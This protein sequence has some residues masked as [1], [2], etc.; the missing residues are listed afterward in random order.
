M[1][2]TAGGVGHYFTELAAADGAELTVVTSTPE[3]AERL[4][5]LGARHSVQSLS[6]AIGPFDLVLESVD[7]TLI[8]FG[9]ASREPAEISFFRLWNGPVSGSIRH[10]DY[11]DTDI[12][13]TADLA[14]LLQMVE[15]GRLH[16]ELGL[17]AD[18]SST[19]SSLNTLRNRGVR[20]NVVLLRTPTQPSSQSPA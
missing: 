10:F 8:W 15:P 3:R 17:V 1:P 6:D 4:A 7:G 11:T 12:A 19:P 9:Q 20:G 18:W 2:G 5:A 14:T 16:P 13:D